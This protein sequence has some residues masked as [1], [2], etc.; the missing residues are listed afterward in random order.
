MQKFLFILWIALI[1]VQRSY[2]QCPHSGLKVQSK[3]CNLPR[4]LTI[5]SLS[6]TELKVS[7][8]GSENQS[9]I[10]RAYSAD[11]ST[12]ELESSTPVCNNTTCSSIIDVRPG[13]VVNWSVQGVC[14]SNGTI[15]L[16]TPSV[17]TQVSIPLCSSANDMMLIL[18]PNPSKGVINISYSGKIGNYLS[19]TVYD[20]NGKIVSENRNLTPKMSNFY[21]MDLQRL[22]VGTYS[23]E[24][25]NGLDKKRVKFVIAR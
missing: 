7:W 13:S 11:D 23:L 12:R 22:S 10:V 25:D 4:G 8:N 2:S 6:C 20:M 18:Y 16:S 15:L 5:T 14:T 1:L 9:Y 3:S 17:G 19:F 21:T 24:A